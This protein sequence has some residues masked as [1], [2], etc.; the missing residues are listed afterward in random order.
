[1][2]KPL[3]F[4][5]LQSKIH[6][7]DLC[8]DS[9]AASHHNKEPRS[10]LL[11][12]GPILLQKNWASRCLQETELWTIL[13]SCEKSMYFKPQYLRCSF[14]ESP[15]YGMGNENDK[16][17]VS[18]SSGHL[19]TCSQRTLVLHPH[20]HWGEI[21]RATLVW[22]PARFKAV[23]VVL[24]SQVLVSTVHLPGM[25]LPVWSIVP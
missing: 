15:I 5:F 21:K 9:S 3:L 24:E 1:M 4:A 22:K 7:T 2:W 11:K 19:L 18:L 25:R 10:L 13:K 8:W 23:C 14:E 12:A 6:A 20:H 16:R 17:S